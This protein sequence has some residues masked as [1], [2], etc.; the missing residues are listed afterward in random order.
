M[1]TTATSTRLHMEPTYS[2]TTLLDG[3]WWPHTTDLAIELPAIVEAMG[4]RRGPITHALL[5]P[6]DWNLPHPSRVAAGGVRIR[7]GWYTAQ[8]AGLLTLV[9]DFGRDRFDLLVVPPDMS[10]AAATEAMTAAA[11]PTNKR[12]AP[13]LIA[14]AGQR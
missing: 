5:N 7:V 6:A 2:K 12:R 8:P 3:G 4:D 14:D 13:A 1:T 11:D 10:D 9:C